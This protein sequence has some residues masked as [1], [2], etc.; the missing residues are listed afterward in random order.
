MSEK[1][2]PCPFCG[3][4]NTTLDYYEISCPQELGTI[5]VCNDCGASAK[6]IVDWN[7][8]PIEDALNARIVQLEAELKITDELLKE[9]TETIGAVVACCT[10]NSNDDAKIGIYGIDQKAFTRIDQFITHYNDAISAGKVSVDVK[11]ELTDAEIEELG[12]QEAERKEFCPNCEA[13]TPCT[14]EAELFVCDICG[15]DFA[16]Y[17]VSRNRNVSDVSMTRDVLTD[18]KTP[19]S[20]ENTNPDYYKQE[21][22]SRDALN[23]RIAELEAERRWIPVSERLPEDG[24]VVWLWDGNNLG[25]GYYL[26]LSGC[27]M[28]RDTPLRRIKPTH[29]MPLPEPPEVK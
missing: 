1:L 29:W 24:E 6:S 3:S 17:I 13:V 19:S 15:E 22:A 27:F 14:H 11:R 4:S 7:T 25:M 10:Y 21:L 5:V 9:A 8:R 18:I 12:A 28:D 20:I 2:K 23:A 16:K 26:V